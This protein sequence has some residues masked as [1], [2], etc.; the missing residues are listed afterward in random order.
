MNKLTYMAVERIA[1]RS[2]EIN[3]ITQFLLN[4]SIGPS[5]PLVA[6]NKYFA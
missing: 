5:L 3:M 4:Y 2:A 1:K 6:L